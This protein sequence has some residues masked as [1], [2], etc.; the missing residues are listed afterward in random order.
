[1]SECADHQFGSEAVGVCSA[2]E[3]LLE[4]LIFLVRTNYTIN[5]ISFFWGTP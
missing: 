2:H 3:I 5:G 4:K 1:M